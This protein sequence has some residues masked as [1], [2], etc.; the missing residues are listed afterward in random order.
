MQVLLETTPNETTAVR[1]WGRGATGG[2]ACRGLRKIGGEFTWQRT[3]AISAL[4]KGNVC[5]GAGNSALDLFGTARAS[6]DFYELGAV[7][8]TTG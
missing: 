6:A 5:A 7:L 3:W 4:C 2:V 8:E 1:G